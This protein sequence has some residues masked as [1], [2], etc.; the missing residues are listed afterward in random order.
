MNMESVFCCNPHCMPC[1]IKQFHQRTEELGAYM[2][3]KQSKSDRRDGLVGLSH[4]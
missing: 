1:T 3:L 4:C 2:D